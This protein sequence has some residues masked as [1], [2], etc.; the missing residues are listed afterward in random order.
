LHG[1]LIAAGAAS[2]AL[3]VLATLVAFNLG[4]AARAD[5]DRLK[6]QVSAANAVEGLA[7]ETNLT[8]FHT[9][10]MQLYPDISDLPAQVKADLQDL[11]KRGGELQALG[12][13][14]HES[15]VVT[16]YRNAI[17]AY[18]KF[19]ETPG[20]PNLTPAQLQASA[21]QYDALLAAMDA[22]H[23]KAEAVLGVEVARLEA[24]ASSTSRSSTLWMAVLTL[25]SGLGMAILLGIT[26]RSTRR[27]LDLMNDVV[28][29]VR[30]G[31]LTA[32]VR[33]RGSDEIAEMGRG[34]DTTLE[35]LT[36]VFGGIR[37]ANELLATSSQQLQQVATRV[38]AA[39]DDAA[40]QAQVVAGA[41]G[42]VS[43]N[44]Q[45]VASGS[46]EM[47]ASISEIARNAQEAASVATGAVSSVDATTQTMAKLGE[48]SREVGDVIRLITSIAEQTNLLALNA[49][50]E[51]A[52]AGAAGRGFAVV[53]DEVKQLAQET[54]R[55]TEDI[56]RRI[57]AIQDDADQAGSAI[58]EIAS[59]IGRIQEYQTVIAAAVEEQTAT[60]RDM[61]RGVGDAAAGSGR[62]AQNI[63]G[64]ASGAGATEVAVA[65]ARS[66]SDDLLR[67]SQQLSG[68]VN[69]FRY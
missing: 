25:S 6:V 15:V 66:S 48:S 43:R 9:T 32:R 27:R 16:A 63:E 65:E 10:A 1:R 45:Q 22:N 39:A 2:L 69:G 55:A 44:V 62:I 60:T 26:A 68:L 51:A 23:E 42:E 40:T 28:R 61:Q 29:R 3:G 38:G 49:T 13:T 50:I 5:V 17:D 19:L 59:V 36:E 33:A 7:A 54:A 52:R 56:S 30:D 14:G 58:G 31:D 37:T 4:S 18:V 8:A 47:G 11:V 57:E 21:K 24:A 46:Q 12:L 35:K 34:L 64:V 53:A 67:M 41:A 20:M